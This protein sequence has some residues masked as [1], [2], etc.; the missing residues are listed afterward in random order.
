MA[1]HSQHQ[2]EF[3]GKY[4]VRWVFM[5]FPAVFFFCVVQ[6]YNNFIIITAYTQFEADG[7]SKAKEFDLISWRKHWSDTYTYRYAMERGG[8]VYLCKLCLIRLLSPQA[9]GSSQPSRPPSAL[10]GSCHGLRCKQ[11][12]LQWG[13]SA[14]GNEDGGRHL[15]HRLFWVAS[16]DGHGHTHTHTHLTY[17]RSARARGWLGWASDE[18][19]KNM[20]QIEECVTKCWSLCW[21]WR[22]M[23]TWGAVAYRGGVWGVQTPTPPRK[24]RR[25]SKI[26]P[27]STRLWKLLKIAEFRKPTPQDVRKKRQ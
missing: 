21:Q 2:W 13:W 14:Y 20:Q 1:S 18:G 22:C 12:E 26:V 10:A 4:F 16:L 6:C 19:S 7:V 5:S 11:E 8:V 17:G 9:S 15:L 3:C 25:P 24:F 23:D 27:N